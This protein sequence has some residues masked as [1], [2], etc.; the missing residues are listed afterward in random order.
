MTAFRVG[1]EAMVQRT[2]QERTWRDSTAMHETRRCQRWMGKWG[3][4]EGEE[5]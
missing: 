5:D 3:D 1:V 4:T 2:L